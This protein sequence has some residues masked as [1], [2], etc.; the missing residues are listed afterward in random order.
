MTR[1]TLSCALLAL[2]LAAGLPAQAQNP[3]PRDDRGRGNAPQRDSPAERR[4][5]PGRQD[6][7]GYR[8]NRNDRTERD[9]RERRSDDRRYGSPDRRDGYRTYRS[10][11]G[12]GPDHAFYRGD[13]LPWQ[14]RNRSY[15]VDDWRGHRLSAPP[16][17]YHW[18][19]TGADY[20]LVAITTGVI[21]QLLLG[22]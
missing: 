17:G 20:V 1:P 12:A 16:R 9:D 8:D 5:D 21:L 2:C 3:G 13:R 10:D 15:V 6:N 18:V 11:R 14:Y 22:N 4:A 19:Q 7:R